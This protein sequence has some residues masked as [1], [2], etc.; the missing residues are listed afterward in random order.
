[1]T[2]TSGS[3]SCLGEDHPNEKASH[4]RGQRSAMLTIFT[5]PKPFR[6]HIN[7]IQRNALK[8][9]TLL[10]PDVEVILFGDEEGAAE[11]AR[12]L[13]IR[14]DP[15][16]E[17]N[18]FGTNLLNYMFDKAEA[19]AR[20]DVLCYVN[21]DIILT[22]DFIRAVGRVRAKYSKF[23]MVGRR[24]DAPITQP[25][26][27]SD[28]AW[29]E[30]A[31]NVALSANAQRD[32]WWIDYFVFPRGFYGR[33]LPAFA[34]GRVRWDNWMIWKALDSESPVVDASPA[35]IAVH[36]NHDYSHHPQG[37][38]GVW[39]GE[40]AKVNLQLAGGLEHLRVISDATRELM[41][42]GRIRGTWVRKVRGEVQQK[43]ALIWQ[44]LLE[45]TYARRRAMGLNREGMKQLKAKIAGRGNS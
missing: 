9:W 5:T 6:G 27:F 26:D 41:P 29:G 16:V 25:I 8:S 33:D 38:H 31:R 11:A 28:P 24:W 22:D 42:S 3:D 10:H 18:E 40:E 36:Q 45:V 37:K 44:A 2:G 4:R 1:M 21:C 32:E 13:G 39:E 7:I 20:H 34:V 30:K 14:H 15:D 19:M 17:R 35:V 23:L 12:E 43:W